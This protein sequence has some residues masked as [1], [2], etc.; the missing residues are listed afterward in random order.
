ML[1]LVIFILV[2]VNCG[3]PP[4]PTGLVILDTSGPIIFPPS[5]TSTIANPN[6]T[7]TYVCIDNDLILVGNDV[8]TC[9]DVA[10]WSPDLPVC[11]SGKA[12]VI[13]MTSD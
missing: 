4:A 11:Q 6:A 7:A 1:K 12:C 2:A 5:V 3:D 8:L 9:T 10:L 13:M